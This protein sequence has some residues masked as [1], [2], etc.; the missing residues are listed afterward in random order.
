MSTTIN[1]P[2]EYAPLLEDVRQ[3]IRDPDNPNQ[4]TQEQRDSIWASLEEFGWVYPLITDEGGLIGDGEQRVETL[5]EHGETVAPVLR[6]AN[7][8]DSRRRLLRQVLN[9]LRGTHD[10]IMDQLEIQRILEAG[11]DEELSTLMGWDES[12][13]GLLEGLTD[14]L[15]ISN[16]DAP[17]DTAR[18]IVLKYEVDEFNEV[19]DW[20]SFNM[21]RLHLDTREEVILHLARNDGE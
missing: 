12:L 2:P 8:D 13:E 16:L 3:L 14:G 4:T 15:D 11:L 6:L 1:V 7:L 10:P 5:I 21:A 18:Q 19:T 9:K 17:S 20:L